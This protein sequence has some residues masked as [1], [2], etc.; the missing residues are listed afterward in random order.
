LAE[1]GQMENFNNEL[2][3]TQSWYPLIASSRVGRERC[4][5]IQLFGRRLVVFREKSGRVRVLLAR[6]PH[7]GADLSDGKVS[8][9]MLE[10]P[11]HAWKFDGDGPLSPSGPR[12]APS[13]AVLDVMSRSARS[14]KGVCID[15]QPARPFGPGHSTYPNARSIFMACGS[16]SIS[17]LPRWFGSKSFLM[18][19]SSASPSVSASS[20]STR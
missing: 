14:S 16:I 5:G 17:L 9:G 12:K 8:G 7:M 18:W 19:R 13:C 10:C 15:Y 1:S 20:P 11:F 6:C 4:Q 3:H 2:V